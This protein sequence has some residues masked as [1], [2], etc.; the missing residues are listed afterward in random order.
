LFVGLFHADAFARE[1][2]ADVLQVAV[3]V[4]RAVAVDG[5]GLAVV[6]VASSGRYTG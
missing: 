5:E 6:G 1:S 3:Y 2:A 4:D